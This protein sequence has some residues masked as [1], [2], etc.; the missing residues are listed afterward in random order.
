MFESQPTDDHAK[1]IDGAC[2]LPITYLL[3]CSSCCCYARFKDSRAFIIYYCYVNVNVNNY[4]FDYDYDCDCDYDT[5]T[6]HITA[7]AQTPAIV[8]DIYIHTP[9]D[10][11]NWLCPV[12]VLSNDSHDSGYIRFRYISLFID[13]GY[14]GIATGV[15]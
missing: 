5:H 1:D 6:Q 15:L 10:N 14:G 8:Y 9:L 7:N 4:N 11:A 2:S 3:I 12:L 13:R